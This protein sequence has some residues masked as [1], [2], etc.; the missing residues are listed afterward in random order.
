MLTR[1]RLVHLFG[2]T[3]CALGDLESVLKLRD[4]RLERLRLRFKGCLFCFDLVSVMTF[5]LCEHLLELL[6][7]LVSGRGTQQSLVAQRTE[8]HSRQRTLKVVVE[9]FQFVVLLHFH[10]TELRDFIL[11]LENHRLAQSLQAH[12]RAVRSPSFRTRRPDS[13]AD[14][15]KTH[16]RHG[17]ERRSGGQNTRHRRH[18]RDAFRKRRHLPSSRIPDLYAL[19]RFHDLIRLRVAW[20]LLPD[21]RRRRPR[22]RRRTNLTATETLRPKERGGGRHTGVDDFCFG[23]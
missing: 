1:H 22:R 8:F 6:I 10:P 23:V 5:H 2:F 20:R 12:D 18:L 13:A 7:L 19:F 16:T 21:R 9:R 4:A 15:R 11:K 3:K 14:S 17:G